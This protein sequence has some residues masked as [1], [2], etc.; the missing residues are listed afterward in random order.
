MQDDDDGTAAQ[1]VVA[2]VQLERFEEEIADGLDEWLE[3]T[4]FKGVQFG[5]GFGGCDGIFG[6]EAGVW[7]CLL[8]T[9]P[10]PRDGLLSRM[11]SSA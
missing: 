7:D 6:C 4:I 11:P 3:F 10:S 9:S 5:F 8:Y 1:P 2:A